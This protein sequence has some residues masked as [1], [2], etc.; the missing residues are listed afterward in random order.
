MAKTNILYK[1]SMTIKR[2]KIICNILYEYL[3]FCSI[4]GEWVIE[5]G[6][7]MLECFA[8]SPL[9]SIIADPI[10]SFYFKCVFRL[11]ECSFQHS[12]LIMSR[13]VYVIS[14]YL[15]KEK[16]RFKASLISLFLNSTP[17]SIPT[18]NRCHKYTE[19]SPNLG[20]ILLLLGFISFIH[21]ETPIIYTH[22]LE[23]WCFHSGEIFLLREK[24]W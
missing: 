7:L 1:I 12:T 21:C 24:Y 15:I 10:I 4:R 19:R 23:R 13:Y 14:L 22:F 3:L 5:Y 11:G 18:V 16:K 2:G 9:W 17:S 8:I 6:H 20:L